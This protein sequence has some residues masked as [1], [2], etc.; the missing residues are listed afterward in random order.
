MA[1]IF[2]RLARNFIKNG[3]F[4]TDQATLERIVA[5]LDVAGSE[6]RILDPCCGEGAA[7][8]RIR[9]ALTACGAAVHA[10]GVEFDAQRL[11]NPGREGCLQRG[12]IELHEQIAE[13]VEFGWPAGVSHPVPDGNG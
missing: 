8:H 13:A 1:L 3:Y 5:A 10:F 7:L 4:P 6:L 12:R 9:E 2:P 11:V